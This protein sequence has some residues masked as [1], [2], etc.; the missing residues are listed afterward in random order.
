MLKPRK[1]VETMCAYPVDLYKPEYLYKLD[2][3]EHQ[4]G[5][6]PKVLEVLKN[7]EET[8]IKFLPTS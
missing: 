4:Y 3:N 5:P 6:S 2:E 8:A 7:L 1:T